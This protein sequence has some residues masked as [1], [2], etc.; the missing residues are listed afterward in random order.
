MKRTLVTT[1][2]LL[3]WCCSHLS[4]RAS[5]YYIALTGTDAAV[6]SGASPWRTIQHGVDALKAGDTL[7]IGPGTYREQI[8]MHSGGTA[9]APITLSAA[10]GAH[11]VV[12]G[13]DILQGGW[14]RAAGAEDGIYAHDWAYRF[15]ISGPNELTHPD[16][17]EHLL[18]GRAEQVIH[19]GRLLR[20]VLTR[21]QLAPGTFF[22]D[23]DAKKLVAWLRGSDDPNRAEMEASVRSNWLVAAAPVAYVHVRGL[24]F[25]Y[26]ANHAQCGAFAVGQRQ[27]KDTAATARGWVVEDCVFERTNGAGA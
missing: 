14:T 1:V 21:Q 19:G 15:P 9:G 25:R 17:K 23:L 11:V 2:V 12:S 24:T 20:Q 13:A 4:A 5:T 10:P 26:A 6:G 27:G 16:D 18:T 22:V 8:E 7:L 3:L